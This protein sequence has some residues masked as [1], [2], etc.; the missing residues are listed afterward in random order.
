MKH[1]EGML[2]DILFYLNIF[3][4]LSVIYIRAHKSQTEFLKQWL[5]R[6]EIS[7]IYFLLFYTQYSTPDVVL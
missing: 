3:I 4:T 5:N 7:D 1:V 2:Q 6:N